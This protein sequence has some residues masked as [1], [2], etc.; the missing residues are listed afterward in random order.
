MINGS[1]YL[2]QL[3]VTNPE[4]YGAFDRSSA[5][6]IDLVLQR[7]TVV[8][9]VFAL[10]QVTLKYETS[11]ET[12]EDNV[13]A[14]DTELGT[15]P[16]AYE[17]GKRFVGWKIKN[18][19][20]ILTAETKLQTGGIY[21]LVPMF[22]AISSE[23]KEALIPQAKTVSFYNADSTEYGVSWQM[24]ALPVRPVIEVYRGE[25]IEADKSNLIETI[26]CTF[27]KFLPG[28]G[29][30]DHEW[31]YR[32]YGVIDD[33]DF[34]TEYTVRFGDLSAE[35]W[36]DNYTFTT[37]AAQDVDV[38]KFLFVTDT[39]AKKVV[40]NAWKNVMVK[41]TATYPDANFL[42]HG[43][44]YFQFGD[45]PTEILTYQINSLSD[46]LFDVPLMGVTGNHEDPSTGDSTIGY[47][48]VA[49]LMNIDYP[50]RENLNTPLMLTRGAVYSFDYGPVHILALR[51]N[52]IYYNSAFG[53]AVNNL[54][55]CLSPEQVNWIKQDLRKDKE[56][57]KT[58]W[59]IA[60][61]HDGPVTSRVLNHE[62]GRGTAGS[63][64]SQ[65]L[66]PLFNNREQDG[67]QGDWGT[68]DLVL[69]GHT[70][71]LSSSYPMIWDAS[72]D[73]TTFD[74]GSDKLSNYIYSKA[75][76]FSNSCYYNKATANSA[77][78]AGHK[79][80]ALYMAIRKARKPEGLT[81]VNPADYETGYA[82]FEYAPDYNGDVGVCFYTLAQSGS[83]YVG[84]ATL[85]SW[86]TENMFRRDIWGGKY[87]EAS[88]YAYLEV[89]STELKVRT[90]AVYQ[91]TKTQEAIDAF[92]LTK[93][94]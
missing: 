66:V 35:S 87:A 3:K 83:S 51:S 73:P 80:L 17:A 29:L 88:A 85:N 49:S 11:G 54:Q 81:V 82:T 21:K 20:I 43:G 68:V 10:A 23:E 37:R 27:K 4:S 70:H 91:S 62:S 16:T 18:S 75:N 77:F 7:N 25:T 59:V 34:A 64:L 69:Q 46:F 93:Q 6:S 74:L 22:E 71:G 63:V 65:Q 89:N 42:L 12:I 28:S 57:P 14:I 8:Q 52:D 9:A 41:A 5:Q 61:M 30:D 53:D 84:G 13:T 79:E 48:C 38:A 76:W 55:L 94:A 1:S 40:D 39:Q 67:S 45:S 2:S 32:A 31:L 19:D 72:I 47:D 92:M 60:L 78:A 24:A 33:L 36:C 15:L 86:W 44:D 26:D 50:D 90:H 58:K 56:N